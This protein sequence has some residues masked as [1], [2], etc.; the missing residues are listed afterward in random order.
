MA[1]VATV[2]MAITLA[3]K[4][5]VATV[6]IAISFLSKKAKVP[7]LTIAIS[8]LAKGSSGHCSNGHLFCSKG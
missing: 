8:I 5:V 3:Q 1:V 6:A 7:A 4:A 2:V